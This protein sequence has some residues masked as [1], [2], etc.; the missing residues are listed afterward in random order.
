MG[1]PYTLLALPIAAPLLFPYRAVPG[2]IGVVFG[3]RDGITDVPRTSF[4]AGTRCPPSEPRLPSCCVCRPKSIAFTQPVA[5]P[6]LPALP[7]S[8][9]WTANTGSPTAYAGHQVGRTAADESS[10]ILVS[11]H[12]TVQPI[13]NVESIPL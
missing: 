13:G 1:T 5:S 10:Y 3:A 8:R 9:L 12:A 6:L 4:G 7:S 11:Q 2:F